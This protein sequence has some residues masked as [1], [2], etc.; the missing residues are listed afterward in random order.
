LK[1]EGFRGLNTRVSE[2]MREYCLSGGRVEDEREE[3]KERCR[4]DDDD[5]DLKESDLN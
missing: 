5:V 2:L 4:N 3:R 1:K